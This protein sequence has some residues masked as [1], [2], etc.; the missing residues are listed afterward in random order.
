[1]PDSS[2]IKNVVRNSKIALFYSLIVFV[3]GFISR[4]VFLDNLG[5]DVLGLNTTALNLLQFI[6]LAELGISAAVSSMLFRPIFEQDHQ[7][8]NEIMSVQGWLYRKVA[9]LVIAVSGVLFCFF[10]IIFDHIALPLWYTY[11][12]FSVL[13]FSSLLGYF[14]NYKQV[15]LFAAQREYA[16]VVGYKSVINIAK[17]LAQ[18]AAIHFF[19][20]GY[21]W[22]LVLEMVFAI[23]ASMS[24]NYT[25]R[26]HIPY[27]STSRCRGRELSKKY[28]D[29]ITKIKQV[30]VHRLSIVVLQQSQPLIIFAFTSLAVVAIFRTICLLPQV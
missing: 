4:K 7:A 19:A 18:I 30:F 24:L 8:V 1:M 11:A 26:R 17:V 13:L 27:L 25:I 14:V 29:I 10:P 3:V 6:N 12:T 28:P 5:V 23:L 15:V 2:R 9:Y 22:W 21:I 20:Y 16:I